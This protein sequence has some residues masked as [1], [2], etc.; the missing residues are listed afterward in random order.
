MLSH[1]HQVFLK[2]ASLS[3]FSKA[4]EV[5]FMS[6]P[7]VSKHIKLLEIKYKIT[8]FLRQKNTIELTPAGKILYTY[9]QQASITQRQLEFEISTLKD[10]SHATG[11]LLIGAST[12]VALYIVPKILSGF[13]RQHPELEIRLVNRNSENITAALLSHEIDLGIIEVENKIA[14]ITYQHFMTDEI[15]AVCSAGSTGAGADS[16]S[17]TELVKLPIALRERGSGTLAALSQAL[18]K[19]GIEISDLNVKVRLGGTEALKNFLLAD[20]CIGFLPKRSV[21][22]ELASAELIQLNVPGLTIK[23]NFFF[24]KRKGT[25]EFSLIKHFIRFCKSVYNQ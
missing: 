12:T 21:I 19:K 2:V 24:I 11:H 20:Q 3:S 8:L 1:S 10:A 16:I 22:R 5:L 9:L 6:Q 4:S 18:K 17:F 7:A 23:R 15:I 13:H 14:A 25:E